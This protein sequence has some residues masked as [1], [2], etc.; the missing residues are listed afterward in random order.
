MSFANTTGTAANTSPICIGY[1]SYYITFTASVRMHAIAM[2]VFNVMF[3][4]VATVGNL[5]VLW[6]F[7]KTPVLRN[8][9]NYLLGNLCLTDL[10]VG[11]VTQPL[12]VIK[13]AQEAAGVH[14]C[15]LKKIST[16]F[17]FTGSSISVIIVAVISID[18]CF[19]ISS[20][21]KY[22]RIV[23]LSLYTKV[24]VPIWT[25]TIFAN[26]LM[27]FEVIEE[28]TYWVVNS[29]GFAIAF[30]V[31]LVSYAIIF[32]TV[33]RQSRRARLVN[34]GKFD[35]TLKTCKTTNNISN[36]LKD[37][38][39][40][41]PNEIE[42]FIASPCNTD[43]EIRSA[44]DD[45]VIH[46]NKLESNGNHTITNPKCSS[47][48]SK[49]DLKVFHKK[50]K[51]ASISEREGEVACA[52][53]CKEGSR[54]RGC[55]SSSFHLQISSCAKSSSK[56]ASTDSNEKRGAITIAI[57]ILTL[58]VC[59]IPFTI[60]L[61]FHH[62]FQE[63]GVFGYLYSSWTSCFIYLN[64]SLNPIIYCYRNNIIRESVLRKLKCF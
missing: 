60:T 63:N 33:I 40:R 23:S 30:F 26:I 15:I 17:A 56:G 35:T 19:A 45:D 12:F 51:V 46:K 2:A 9:S 16:L 43:A 41:Q 49:D 64:S 37:T 34:L 11:C 28:N 52:Q 14:N 58:T 8:S 57:I 62:I 53:N 1:S 22:Q 21:Y 55:S 39:R 13:Y 20:P 18:R 10:F 47:K 44:I 50:T 42:G 3:S 59:Y 6:T 54:P 24:L 5:L 61:G 29:T 7:I 32:K 38:T 27:A 48:N 4:V 25:G 36:P 31:V